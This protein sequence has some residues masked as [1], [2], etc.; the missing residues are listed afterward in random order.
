MANRKEYNKC[1]IP[2][3]SGSKP[4]EQRKLDFCVGAKVCSGKAKDRA[5]AER[6]C[7]LPKEPKPVKA[8]RSKDGAKSCE[9]EVLDLSQCMLDY[10]EEK[11]IYRQVLNINSVGVAMVNAMM[12]CKR[13]QNPQ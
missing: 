7:S 5:E 8:R 12:E 6:L 11:G 2:Y 3:I 13:C 1:I 9:K 4:K 10:F